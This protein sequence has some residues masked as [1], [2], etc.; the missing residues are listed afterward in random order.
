MEKPASC[1]S[2]GL[3]LN[4]TIPMFHECKKE[5]HPNGSMVQTIPKIIPYTAKEAA[6]PRRKSKLGIP[7]G[8][9]VCKFPYCIKDR[10]KNGWCEETMKGYK[11]HC[12]PGFSGSHCTKH[13]TSTPAI[14]PMPPVEP[15][16]QCQ[17]SNRPTADS[18]ESVSS[19]E[20]TTTSSEEF[21]DLNIP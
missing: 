1:C 12:S 16:P 20:I 6:C 14:R 17:T 2:D 9:R 19:E 11:C 3:G 8:H 7:P 13:S 18:S 10:C 15:S 21:T 5:L 4:Y